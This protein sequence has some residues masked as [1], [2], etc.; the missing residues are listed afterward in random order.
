MN[1]KSLK[2]FLKFLNIFKNTG[3]VPGHFWPTGL[4][5]RL[6]LTGDVAHGTQADDTA[7]DAHDAITTPGTSTAARL[8]LACPGFRGG[9]ADGVR[10]KGTRSTRW[11]R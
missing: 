10:T 11:A 1:F 8:E 7:R 4:Q 9:V 5:A 2:E 6:G 3:I